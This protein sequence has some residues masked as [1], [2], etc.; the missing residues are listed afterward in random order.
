MKIKHWKHLYITCKN[1]KQNK[2]NTSKRKKVAGY[3]GLFLDP[4]TQ[5]NTRDQGQPLHCTNLGYMIP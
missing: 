3:D 4:S 5:V 1:K 2:T